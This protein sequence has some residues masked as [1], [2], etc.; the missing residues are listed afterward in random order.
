MRRMYCCLFLL[1]SISQLFASGVPSLLEISAGVQRP[2]RAFLSG[3]GTGNPRL[4]FV[5][6]K[7][8]RLTINLLDLAGRKISALVEASYAAGEHSVALSASGPGRYIV[9][10]SAENG[11]SVNTV[12]CIGN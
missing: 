5:M 4:T 11:A 12:V 8:E 1:L 7:P 9:S 6:A 10:I 3:S 2:A